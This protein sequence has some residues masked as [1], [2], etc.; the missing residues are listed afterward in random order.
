M[1]QKI[2]DLFWNLQYFHKLIKGMV[3]DGQGVRTVNDFSAWGTL[4][5]PI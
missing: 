5:V 2:K 4:K 1:E 3:L